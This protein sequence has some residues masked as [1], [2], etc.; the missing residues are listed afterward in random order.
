MTRFQLE[1]IIRAAG[2][3]TGS[4]EII[5]IGSQAILGSFP[6]APGALLISN[7]ADLFPTGDSAKADLVDGSIG[8]LSPFHGTFGYYAHGVG[9]ETATLP[10]GW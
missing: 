9:L 8:E 3:I 5:I 4:R 6:N 2:A 1:H 10:T 7:E